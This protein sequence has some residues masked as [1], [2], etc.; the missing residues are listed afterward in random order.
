MSAHAY[1]RVNITGNNGGS[2]VEIIELQFR[3]TAGVTSVPSGGAPLYSSQNPN[4]NPDNLAAAAFDGSYSTK[5]TSNGNVP[6]YLGYHFASP[7]Y[8]A[9][10]SI[11]DSHASY[12]PKDFT[13]EYSDDG[14]IWTAISSVT[15]Q[16]GWS[17]ERLYGLIVGSLAGN[18]IEGTA[19]TDWRVTATR[20]D[21]GKEVASAVFTGTTYALAC[22]TLSPCLITLSPKVDYA[23][24]ADK[25]AGNSDFVVA[26]NPD[27]VPHLFKV[28][29]PGTFAGTEA[30]WN[31]SGTTTQ[32][33]AVLTYIA[34]LVD[35]VTIGPKI[36]A[37]A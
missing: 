19:I 2:L 13:I 27:A 17:G 18:I 37:P 5:W 24:F 7:I 12:A 9:E 33:S 36:P 10:V 28:T 16:T 3:Q 31:L 34:L 21:N 1:W 25:V 15:N 23:W 22:D 30:N 32:G 8:V 29:T 35:P 6:Q 11:R 20:C 4:N 14:S 26:S